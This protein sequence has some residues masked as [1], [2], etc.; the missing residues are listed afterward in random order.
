MADDPEKRAATHGKIVK[1]SGPTVVAK[2]MK[3][4]QIHHRVRVGSAGLLGEVIRLKDDRA[5]IQVYE[6]TT[7]LALG[8]EVVDVGEPLVVELGPGLLTSLFDGIQRPLDAIR[9]AEGDFLRPGGERPPLSRERRWD[10]VPLI[11]EGDRVGPG[12]VVGEVAETASITHRILIPPGRFGRIVEVR[13]GPYTIADPIAFIEDGIPIRNAPEL[14]GPKPP[15]VRQTPSV[16]RPAHH[17]ATG[18]RYPLSAGDRRDRRHPR[19]VRNR[20][21]GGRADPREICRVRSYRLHRL[22]RAGE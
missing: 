14:A 9:A 7:G 6:E 5:T 15:S 22:R 17:A 16:G 12:D 13:S 18:L 2:G 1:V 10:F 4:A 20:Q 3:E 21:N 8:E 11:K 19:R